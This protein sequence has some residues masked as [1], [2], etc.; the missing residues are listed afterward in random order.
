[1]PDGL[2]ILAGGMEAIPRATGTL[3][4]LAQLQETARFQRGIQAI[5]GREAAI[6]EEEAPIRRGLLQTQA[7]IAGVK[8]QQAQREQQL[9]QSPWNFDLDPVVNRIFEKSP[10]RKDQYKKLLQSMNIINQ[11]GMGTMHGRQRA[12]AMLEADTK[13]FESVLGRSGMLG[14]VERDVAK[15][16]SDY[17]EAKNKSGGDEA[18]SNVQKARAAYDRKFLEY[19]SM[20]GKFSEGMKQVMQNEAMVNRAGYGRVVPVWDES[21]G[22]WTYQ[23]VA[24]APGAVAPTPRTEVTPTTKYAFAGLSPQNEPLYFDPT[25]PQTYVHREGKL[26]PYT[27]P[28]TKPTTP[29]AEP[30]TTKVKQWVN[31]STLET[32]DV[33][34][35]I[36][37]EVEAARKKNFVPM[38]NAMKADPTIKWKI[39][40]KGVKGAAGKYGS[41]EEV[42]TAFRNK[43]IT[44]EE[45]SRILKE[46]FGFTD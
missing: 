13:L 19:Q 24:Q 20:L 38:E 15:S 17:V 3:L 41:A 45:A 33:D 12:A 40:M 22:Q 37:K 27:G 8:L 34:E 7:D 42:R 10:E 31:T 28:I 5:R 6:H 36:K 26:V 2:A 32:M 43:Q 39:M 21:M 23:S 11:Q 16:W 18:A 4:K 1:M 29:A 9:L 35:N 44:R 25:G 30:K 46:Q 14:D